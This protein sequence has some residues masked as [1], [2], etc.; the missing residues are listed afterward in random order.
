[1]SATVSQREARELVASNAVDVVDLRDDEGWREGHIPGA[2]R[3]G[4][5]LAAKLESLDGERR[6]LIVCNDGGRSGEVADELSRGDRPAVSL[7]GGMAAWL[8]KGMP[9][10]PTGDYSP[11]SDD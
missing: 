6:L 5:D 9:A 2:H 1:M 7:A 3:A 4:D 10:Q 11:A 8:R